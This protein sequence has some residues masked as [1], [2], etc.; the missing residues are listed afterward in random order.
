MSKSRTTRVA[1]GAFTRV[2][3]RSD[4]S[5]TPGEMNLPH[6]AMIE[7]FLGRNLP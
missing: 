5:R 6:Q 1:G 7:P 4:L 3:A 2:A